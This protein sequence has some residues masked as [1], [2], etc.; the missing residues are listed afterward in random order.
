MTA[1]PSILVHSLPPSRIVICPHCTAIARAPQPDH[2]IVRTV[3]DLPLPPGWTWTEGKLPGLG[4]HPVAIPLC[5]QCSAHSTYD[6][7]TFHG[8]RAR[9]RDLVDL[10]MAKK[11]G[12]G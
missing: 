9:A 7:D 11:R 8:E 12:R 1:E 3:A 5:A 4:E 2:L 6:S 10:G